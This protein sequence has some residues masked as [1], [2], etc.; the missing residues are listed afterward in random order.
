M[1]V[2]ADSSPLISLAAIDQ[3]ALL[4]GL[5][6]TIVIPQAV[7]DE[8]VVRGA[9]AAGAAE[10]RT[11][12][13]IETRQVTAHALVLALQ[14]ELDQGEAEAIALAVESGADLLI[15]DERR[16]RRAAARLDVKHI[17]L[18]GVLV[19]A[20]HARLVDAV[21]PLLDDLTAKAGFRVSQM[22]REQVLRAVDE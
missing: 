2:V 16:G 8:V 20:K 10:V 14:A 15:M 17:G 9:G 13:W 22:L 7:Y 3:L 4:H 19:E 21:R 18:L 12:D 1:I 6:G 11:A 5:Y